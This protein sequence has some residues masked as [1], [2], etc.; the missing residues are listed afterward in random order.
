MSDASGVLHWRTLLREN[1]KAGATALVASVIS[2]G[3][4]AVL[5][6]WSGSFLAS[7]ATNAAMP[8]IL[9][10]TLDGIALLGIVT[11]ASAVRDVS[12]VSVAAA[13]SASVRARM[14]AT[15]IRQPASARRLTPSGESMMR[16][17]SDVTLLHQSL[18]RV[19]AVW[20]PSV[21]TSGV[22]LIALF[23]TSMPLAVA[24]VVFVAPTLLF[25]GRSGRRLQ[26]AV[27]L[28]QES[29][30]TLGSAMSES[31]AGVREA[32]VF[33]REAALEARFT[34]ASNASI[35][36]VVREERAAVAHPAVTTFASA[37]ALTALVLV[38]AWWRRSGSIDGEQVTR[39]LV[40]LA[41]LVGP[42]QEAI[43]SASAVA[44]CRAL[45]RRCEEVIDGAR[46]GDA[47]NAT[48]LVRHPGGCRVQFDRAVV[49]T[50]DGGFV[51]GPI[52]LDIARGETIVIRGASGAGKSTLI[53]LIPRLGDLTSGVLR[54]DGVPATSLT[55][56]S[57]RGACAFVP[58]EPYFFSGTL[59]DNLI[60]AQGDVSEH[61]LHQAIRDAHADGIVRRLPE[62]LSTRV[63]SGGENFSVGERQRLALA[64]ALLV[65]PAIL[66]LDEPTAALD[67]ESSAL[68]I[69]S[70]R[71]LTSGR[72]SIIVTHSA[73]L[74]ELAHR[75]V[76]LERGRVAHIAK[77][78]RSARVMPPE[79]V[80]ANTT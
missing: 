32:K 21:A 45:L 56:A 60:F 31:L 70:L 49:Q 52:S 75:I 80:L 20:L 12:L 14:L 42:L 44:R 71:T 13:V 50:L 15:L 59:R 6:R 55:L 25:V 43:R 23:W 16:L 2:V 78:P 73:A 37:V 65:D 33:R 63:L 62:G 29:T 11:F 5:A 38:A 9:R 68:V 8:S 48:D 67:P 57:L 7:L 18:V 19:L 41:L 79:G 26:G 36:R 76:T 10:A 4:L 61:A 24:T 3:A 22:L 58:Q 28:T 35:A 74:H 1:P 47:P 27:R 51:L 72:T 46:E 66:L 30:A 54:I 64:R 53:E 39:Y 77:G 17:A 69:A 40:V 34:L